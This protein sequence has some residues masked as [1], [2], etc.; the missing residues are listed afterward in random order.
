MDISFP[1]NTAPL[2]SAIPRPVP[3]PSTTMAFDVGSGGKSLTV[4]L[5]DTRSGEV[6]RKLVYDRGGRLQSLACAGRGLL[7]DTAR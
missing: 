6:V 3:V 2:T 1:A 4:T 5:A 7:I